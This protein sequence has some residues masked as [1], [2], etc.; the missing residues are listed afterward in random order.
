MKEQSYYKNKAKEIIKN[1][2][3]LTL[4]SVSNDG[5]PWNSPLAYSA[6]SDYN[7]YFGS[8]MNTQHAKNIRD[9]GK[10]FIVI[11]DSQAPDGEGEGVYMTANV[12][13][14]SD[15][16]EVQNAINVMFGNDNKYKVKDFTGESE[17]RAYK[18]EPI[19]VWMNDAEEK[20]DLFYDYRV[21]IKLK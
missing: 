14:L 1:I 7:F 16:H 12:K 4:A 2:H 17:L 11:Y 19:S 6:D 5:T 21:E 3:Y 18:I 20:N 8:P 15:E 9:N 13:E 10:G